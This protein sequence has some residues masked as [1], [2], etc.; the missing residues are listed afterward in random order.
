MSDYTKQ[1]DKDINKE[2]ELEKHIDEFF[3]YSYACHEGTLAFAYALNKTIAGKCLKY[4]SI[5][6]DCYTIIIITHADLMDNSTLNREAAE[7]SGL[8]DGE[9]F[10]MANFTYANSAVVSRMFEHLQ[11]TSFPGISVSNC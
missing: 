6:Y 2:I 3:I 5:L 7:L 11:N 9:T 1:L 8:P 10:T 4:V